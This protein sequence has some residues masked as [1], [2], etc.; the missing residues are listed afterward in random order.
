MTL[1]NHTPPST[2]DGSSGVC[3]PGCEVEQCPS[4][5]RRLIPRNCFLGENSQNS[6][7]NPTSIIFEDLFRVTLLLDCSTLDCSTAKG[8]AKV[9]QWVPKL[10]DSVELVELSVRY[11]AALTCLLEQSLPARSFKVIA[12]ASVEL[13]CQNPLD[14]GHA[15]NGAR[16]VLP[17]CEAVAGLF[18]E[19]AEKPTRRRA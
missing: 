16:Q 8:S 1:I 13:C 6:G 5:D 14:E 17:V 18:I 7:Q 12:P 15:E 3:G 9:N 11:P 19:A 4:P 10:P 2:Q